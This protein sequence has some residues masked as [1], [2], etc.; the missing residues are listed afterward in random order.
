M[1]EDGKAR[2]KVFNAEEYRA[3]IEEIRDAKSIREK[4][5]R[6]YYLLQQYEL[7]QIGEKVRIIRKRKEEDSKIVPYI[8]LEESF[9]ILLRI[10]RNL[11]HKARQ[12]M[13][14]A[15]ERNEYANLTVEFCTISEK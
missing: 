3:L 12:L 8:S 1:N 10:H 7:M 15:S 5:R 14:K 6:Q 9:S 11:G 2:R 13:E 4:S